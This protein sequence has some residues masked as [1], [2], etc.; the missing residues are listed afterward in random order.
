MGATKTNVNSALELLDEQFIWG[1][2]RAG[3]NRGEAPGLGFS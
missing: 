3:I 1:P 2:F